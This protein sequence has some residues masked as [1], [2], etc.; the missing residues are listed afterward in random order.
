MKNRKKSEFR[1]KIKNFDFEFL[2]NLIMT[3]VWRIK[4]HEDRDGMRIWL[5]DPF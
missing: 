5:N 1:R 2:D 3:V 4:E